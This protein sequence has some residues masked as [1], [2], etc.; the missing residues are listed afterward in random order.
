MFPIARRAALLAASLCLLA[1]LASA[2]APHWSYEGATGPSHWGSLEPAWRTCGAGRHQSPVDFRRKSVHKAALPP[3]QFAYQRVPLR[4]VDNG[5]SVQVDYPP[6]SFL[7]VGDKRYELLQFHFHRPS[8]EAL[9]GRRRE[10]VAHL[11]HKDGQGQLAVVAVLLEAG[12]PNPLVEVLWDH[13]PPARNSERSEDAVQ[14]DAAGLLPAD[15]G[16]FTVAGS[17]TTPPCS[18]GVT[19]FVLKQPATVSTQQ[20]AR[21]AVRYPMNARPVQPL[22][23]RVVRA[24]R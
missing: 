7:A 14:V 4:I 10:M 22:H 6:G 3:L 18:E 20:V 17:L 15:R 5:H 13:A 16:Y 23:G 11:V 12:A 24:S 9:D 21:F 19:W 8:E 2:Q 1:P